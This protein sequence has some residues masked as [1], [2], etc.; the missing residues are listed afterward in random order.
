MYIMEFKVIALIAIVIAVFGTASAEECPDVPFVKD[1][2]PK[3]VKQK[4]T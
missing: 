4:H 2:Q 3:R 1:F